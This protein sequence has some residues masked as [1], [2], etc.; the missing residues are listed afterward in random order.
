MKQ[1]E[2]LPDIDICEFVEKVYGIELLPYQKK[3]LKSFTDLP[4]GS[5]IVMGRKGP[6]FLDKD[7]KMI[8]RRRN[9]R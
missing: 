2:Q 8:E 6:V 4:E 3:M 1:I 7:G 9:E 5:T